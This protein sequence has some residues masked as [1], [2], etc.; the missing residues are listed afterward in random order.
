MSD[1]AATTSQSADGRVWIVVISKLGQEQ[2]AKRELKQQ[3]FEVYL[4]MKVSE[5][6]KREQIF[7]PFFRRYLFARVPVD[8]DEWREIS[9]TY[10]VSGVLGF[11]GRRAYGVRDSVIEKLK[12]REEGGYIKVGLAEERKPFRAGELVMTDDGIEGFFD[13]VVSESDDN[14]RAAILVDFMGRLT[15][16]TVDLRELRAVG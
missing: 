11:T 1:K 3:G 8:V 2:R 7:S 5:N 16:F 10:G 12:A 9:S 13:A 14:K 4:P 6:K 15:R